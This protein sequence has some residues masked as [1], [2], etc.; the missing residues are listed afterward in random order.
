MRGVRDVAVRKGKED[1]REDN[2]QSE[3]KKKEKEDTMSGSCNVVGC[4]AYVRRKS[5]NE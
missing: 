1:N 2:E 4:L 5:W 3:K